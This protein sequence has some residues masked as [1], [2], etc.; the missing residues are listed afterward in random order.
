MNFII[1]LHI[2]PYDIMFSVGQ[3]DKGFLKSLKAALPKE[4]MVD[5]MNDDIVHLPKECRGRT[6]HHLIGGQ[7][8]IRLPGK[9]DT[10]EQFGTV[11]HEI[12]HAVDFIFRRIG[13]QLTAES[14]EAYAYLIGYVAEQF[15]KEISYRNSHI[16]A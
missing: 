9:P 1:G 12:F 6:F 4:Y 11:S 3:S 2:Y 15:Y 8:I 5:V 10:P 7:T 14:D 13:L 16:S